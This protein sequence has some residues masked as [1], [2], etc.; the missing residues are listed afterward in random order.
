MHGFCPA[1]AHAG[2]TVDTLALVHMHT[3]IVVAAQ[4][5]LRAVRYTAATANAFA[6]FVCNLLLEA[7]RLWIRAPGA[8]LGTAFEKD[9]IANLRPIMHG[10]A[11]DIKY[12][13]F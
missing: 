11:L 2:P 3:A 10:K 12:S 7:L 9:E 13:A 1:Y 8:M 6:V 5:S 4:R